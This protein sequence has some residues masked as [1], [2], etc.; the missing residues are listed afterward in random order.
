MRSFL[1]KLVNR[2][3]RNTINSLYK[4]LIFICKRYIEKRIRKYYSKKHN[5][6]IV[7]YMHIFES[8]SNKFGA[9]KEIIIE[10][11]ICGDISIG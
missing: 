6:L 3:R 10:L 7:L 1:L 4:L 11:L 9:D 5:L 2:I 8:F